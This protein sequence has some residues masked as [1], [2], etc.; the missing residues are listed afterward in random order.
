MNALI[1]R[2]TWDLMSTSPGFLVVSCRW[3]FTIKYHPDST[4]DKY[5]AHVVARGFIQTL[6]SHVAHLN[7]ICVIFSRLLARCEKY[8]LV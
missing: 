6:T 4:I 1:L 5:K 2:Q 7:S 3:V 8:L